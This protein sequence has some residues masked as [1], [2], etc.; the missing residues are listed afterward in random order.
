MSQGQAG[1]SPVH[2]SLAIAGQDDDGLELPNHG[3]PAQMFIPFLEKDQ[4][5]HFSFRLRTALASDT[6]RE[7][8]LRVR[9]TY[10]HGL[11]KAV[12]N[13]VSMRRDCIKVATIIDLNNADHRVPAAFDPERHIHVHVNDM[14]VDAALTEAYSNPSSLR[15]AGRSVLEHLDRFVT[16]GRLDLTRPRLAIYIDQEFSATQALVWTTCAFLAALGMG[17]ATGVG[18]QDWLTGLGIGLSL[19]GF[20]AVVQVLVTWFN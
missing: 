13:A 5:G 19:F 8:W 17:V 4:S 18:K 9:A 1:L 20:L 14:R 15:T 6:P 3:R 10:P 11:V 16:D 2:L 12:S 7:W